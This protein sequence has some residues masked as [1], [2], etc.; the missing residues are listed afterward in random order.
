VSLEQAI[1]D[2]LFAIADAIRSLKSKAGPLQPGP[3]GPITFISER[4]ENDVDLR[5]YEVN[6]P[7]VPA[8]TPDGD[9]VTKQLFSYVVNGT[10]FA[11]QELD[12]T[13][14]KTTVEVPQGA[15]VE[16]SMVHVDDDGKSG[17]AKTQNFVAT[18]DVGP[19][20]PGDFGAVTFVSERTVPDA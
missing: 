8:V 4:K 7:A 12:V 11:P 13:V 20:A 17:P 19:D 1:H 15:S 14:M 2:G 3:F 16:L 5:T 6:F 18:D 10:A 9:A